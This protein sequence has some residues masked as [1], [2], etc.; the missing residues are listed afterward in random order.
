M[1]DRN[2]AKAQLSSNL[3]EGDDLDGPAR[4]GA[5]RKLDLGSVARFVQ[6]H[7][8]G[9]LIGSYAIAALWPWPG[10]WLRDLS[11]GEVALFGVPTR[12][13]LPMAMLALLLLN[14][15]LGVSASQLAGLVRSPLPLLA[16]LAA[17][18]A[19]PLALLG[20]VAQ[21]LRFWPDP[22][23]SQALTVGLALVASM[24]VAGSSVAW[25]R[26]VNGDLVLGLGLVLCSTALSPVVTPA[27]LRAAALLAPGDSG[28][29]LYDLAAHGTTL[30]LIV[31]VALPSGLGIVLRA[32]LGE[33]RVD[34]IV[35]LLKLVN[36]VTLLLLIYANASDSLSQAVTRPDADF[37]ALTLAATVGLCAAAFTAGWWVGRLLKAGRDRQTALMFGLGMSNNG[38]VLVLASVALPR[39]PAVLLPVIAYNLVQHLTAGAVAYLRR[40]PE[41]GRE[42]GAAGRERS[43][44][45]E[46]VGDQV[47][48]GGVTR[49]FLARGRQS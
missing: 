48:A 27:A 23:E 28:H 40:T 16:G 21:L 13:T 19:V 47:G 41:P 38:T 15:G 10:L 5:W 6:G 37:L 25:T 17:T 8:L 32:A 43:G 44:P 20:V 36:A 9:L 7:F 34:A 42:E 35:P 11:F 30:F 46:P 39:R 33:A 14:A 18:W 22:A 29:D 31:C 4:G 12:L 26:T 2:P 49:R 24:P 3:A 45:P 1:N